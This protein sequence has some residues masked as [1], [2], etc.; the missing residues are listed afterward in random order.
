MAL[1]NYST[2]IDALKTAG[3]I[4]YLLIKNGATAV[5]KNCQSGHVESLT[6][7]IPTPSGDLP[8]RLPINVEPVLRVLKKQKATNS[9][10][11]ATFEQA[12]RVAWRIIKD[13]VEAQLAI[14]QTEQVKLEQV[15]MPYIVIDRSGRTLFDAMEERQFLLTGGQEE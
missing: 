2:T 14:I 7:K 4:E 13:W 9:R 12:E 15:F 5:M 8:I 1:L 6:F 11:Q 3:E 10:I